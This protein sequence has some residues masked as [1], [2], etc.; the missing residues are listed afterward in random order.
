[1]PNP[2]AEQINSALLD[3]EAKLVAASD[4]AA[5][6]EVRIHILGRKGLLASLSGAMGALSPEERK[7]AGIAFNNAR[8]RCRELIDAALVRIKSSSQAGSGELLDL[9]LPGRRQPLGRKHP[10]V[11]VI[12]EA[13]AIF[14]RLGFIVADGPEIE[15]VFH[16]F[17]ALN[18]PAAHPSRDPGDTFYFADGRLL[19]TQTSPV[20]IR[21]M[22]SQEPPV[23]IVAPG[24]CFRRDTPDATHSMNFH[25]IEGLLIDREV[26][27]AD[28]KSILQKFA[29]EM[30]GEKIKIRLR[31]H[32]FPFTEPSVEYDF[33]CI[34]CNGS[35]CGVCKDSGWLEIAGAGVVDPNVLKNVGYDPEIWSGYAFG[36]GIERI[37]MLRY[38][39]NDIRLLYENDVRFLEQF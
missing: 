30:F 6:E 9:T 29:G 4:E 15:D 26:S 1:M 18:T 8:E 7:T 16:N 3:A 20:Q 27:L 38:R 39:I 36:M 23:R 32:F 31:P 37:A 11:T 21:T 5:V 10:I 19:R 25:Q 13:V 17:D 35:G 33:S 34:M 28:L 22:Q 14:R 12:D 24:R 2:I